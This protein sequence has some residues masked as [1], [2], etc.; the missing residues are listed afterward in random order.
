MDSIG[1]ECLYL[2]VGIS[3]FKDFNAITGIFKMI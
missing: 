1:D 2:K 3:Y